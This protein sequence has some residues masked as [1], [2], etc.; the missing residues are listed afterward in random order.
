MRGH[1]RTI[2]LGK[3]DVLTIHF[4]GHTFEVEYDDRTNENLK[5]T[6]IQ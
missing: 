5:M 4:E 3:F 1:K 6:K 2:S